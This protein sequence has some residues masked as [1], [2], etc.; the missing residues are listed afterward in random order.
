VS[1]PSPLGDRT[2]EASITI[3]GVPLSYSQSMTVRVALE[4]FAM[5]LHDDGLGDDLRGKALHQG[6]LARLAEVRALIRKGSR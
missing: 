1:I 2:L 4:V 3:E 6:Y 5:S